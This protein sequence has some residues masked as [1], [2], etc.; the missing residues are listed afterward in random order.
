MDLRQRA[1]KVA[2]LAFVI[3]GV[4]VGYINFRF[5]LRAIFIMSTGDGLRTI[6][7]VFGGYL[8]L[9]PL[10]LVGIRF[11]RTSAILLLIGTISAF[12]A[13]LFPIDASSMIFMTGRFVLP[14][15]AVAVL[16]RLSLA[17]QSQQTRTPTTSPIPGA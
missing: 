7:G 8:S 1:K 10:T 12:L 17:P 9:L 4:I 15:I 3:L 13:G 14:N 5:G 16:M 6:I 11:A 2:L